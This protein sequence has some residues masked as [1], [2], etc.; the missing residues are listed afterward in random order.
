MTSP[1]ADTTSAR[2]DACS[3]HSNAASAPRGRTVDVFITTYDEPL[4]VLRRTAM[5][6]RAIQYPHRT[7]VLDDGKRDE[8]M[9]MAK[10]LGIGYIRRAG[11][12]NAKAGNLN[13][14]LSV[15]SGDFILQLDTDHVPLPHIVDRILGY[16]NDPKVAFIQTP[17]D[18]YNTDSFTHVFNEEA[19][20][21]WEEN[22]IFY[23]LLQPGKDRVNA[24]FLV[25]EQNHPAAGK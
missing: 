15:T 3:I 1:R 11:N 24:S 20:T 21:L 6:A 4:E 5:G 14:A 9:E 10:E 18:F 23:S 13:F 22:R 8:V 25:T 12:A 7:Y 19:R 2:A 16:F 17:Q